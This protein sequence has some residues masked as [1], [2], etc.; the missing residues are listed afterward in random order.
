[1]CAETTLEI[2]FPVSFVFL[3]ACKPIHSSLTVSFIIGP[4]SLI[5]VVAGVSHFSI[6]PFHASFPLSLIYRAIFVSQSTSSISHAIDPLALILD[7][8]LCIDVLSIS[9][10]E[11]IL[12]LSIICWTIWPLIFSNTC[13]LIAFEFSLINSTI[14]P[15]ELTFTMKK[16]MFELT[17]V[18]MSI[19]E[20]ACAL[21]V[22][23]FADLN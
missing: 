4:L 3:I 19:S 7:S 15:F 20:L 18:G 23:Y 12:H 2:I 9:M 16:T 10:S 14:G 8:F 13:D 17:L 1:M 5:V 21:T 6:S 22:I 11:T